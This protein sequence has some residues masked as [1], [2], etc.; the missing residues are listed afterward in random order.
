M[1]HT[2]LM[3]I[4][5]NDVDQYPLF[6][7]CDEMASKKVQ[8]ECFTKEM[9]DRFTTAF[10]DTVFEVEK[11]INDTLEVDFEIDEDG[12]IN[13]KRIQQN[14]DIENLIPGFREE[15]GRR[16]KDE[17]VKAALKRGHE[18]SI[19]FKLPIVVNTEQ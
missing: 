2:E 6:D 5:W 9:M 10:N 15:I 8:K 3:A 19:R 14:E 7:E 18:V 17:T 1:V 12:F 4:D 11:E 16:L 13:I